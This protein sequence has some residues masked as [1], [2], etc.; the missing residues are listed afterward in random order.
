[1][2][3]EGCTDSDFAPDYGTYADN[4]RS[5]SGHHF[6]YNNTPV[7]W[8]THR[9]SLFAQSCYEA[10]TYAAVDAAKEAVHLHRLLHSMGDGDGTPI[11]LHGDN[12]PSTTNM[13]N[14]AD[15][16]RSK[17]LDRQAHYLRDLVHSGEINCS[18][19]PAHQVPKIAPMGSP[20]LFPHRLSQDR[21]RSNWRVQS[22]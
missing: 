1:M 12:K 7:H 20:D 19:T 17:A 14:F 6:D 21:S 5:T 9:Q 13:H 15:T 2:S 10:E 4:Y 18:Y 22:G 16:S 3:I 8:A 11:H